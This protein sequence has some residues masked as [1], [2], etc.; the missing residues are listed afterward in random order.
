VS[1]GKTDGRADAGIDAK[2]TFE[3]LAL[4][5]AMPSGEFELA[6]IVAPAI[7]AYGAEGQTALELQ[8]ALS[9]LPREAHPTTVARHLLPDGVRLV[10]L[11]LLLGRPEL[12]GRLGRP[13]PVRI[14]VAVVPDVRADDAGP[15]GH[16]VFVPVLQHA[17]YVGRKEELARRLTDELA[18]LPSALALDIDGWRRLITYAPA[19]IEPVAV[20]LAT[21]P[22][23]EATG[24]KALAELERRR[25]AIT[26]LDGAGRRVT[27]PHP[28]PPVVGRDELLG[29]LSRVLGSAGRRSVLLV[30]DEAAGKSALVMAWVARGEQRDPRVGPA[31]PMWA[32]SAAEL[33]A[34]ASGPG[35]WQDRIAAVLTAAEAL[36]A[37]LYF[38]DFGALFADRPAE[39]GVELGAAMRRSIVDGRVRV[40]GELTAVALDRAERREVSLIGA[41]LRI[42]VP[43]TDPATTVMACHAWAA[44]WAHTAPHRPQ[45]AA[46]AV[47]TAVELAR[48]YLPYRA[49]PGKA[50][51]L[52][53]ELRV[54]HDAGRD[55]RGAGPVLGEPELYAAFSW[56]TGIPE[57]LLADDRS[58]AMAEVIAALRRRMV[59]Q[60]AA[61]R[62]VAE[63]ICVAK[64]RLAPADKPLASLLFVGPS[65]VGK[66]ELA[67]AVAAYLFGAPDRMVRLDMSEY[68][69]PWAAERL[70]GGDG[71]G[72]GRLTA[73]VRS[74]PFGVVLLDEIEKAHPAVFDLL[75]QVLGE[76]RLTDG[77]G[78]TTYFHNAIIVLTSNLGTRGARG[79]LGLVTA[80]A[81]PD[82][83]ARDERRYRDAVL[84]A[85]RP[86]LINRLDQIVVFHP[87][88]P[89]EIAR[90][91]EIAVGRLA[92][93]RGLTQSGVSLDI[94]P[95]A[96]E[97]LAD[98]GFSAELGARALRR[99]LEDALMKPA[100][101][102]L[103]RAGAEARGGTLTVRATHALPGSPPDPEVPRPS[104]ARLGEVTGEIT[105]T[106]WR[107]AQATG[108]RMVR[109]ALALATL[110]RDAD[111]EL[112]LPEAIAVRDRIAELE[113]TLATAAGHRRA[114]QNPALPGHEIA[115]LAT[116]HARLRDRWAAC[117]AGQAELHAA[118]ELG[119]EALAR[120][121][122]AIDLIDAAVAQRQKFRRDLFWLV[123]AQKPVRPGATLLVHSPDARAA[124]VAWTRL[125][126][127]AA[128]HRQWR[129]SVHL[130]GEQA[131]GWHHPWGP[132]HDLAWARSSFAARAHPAALVRIAGPGADV[133]FGLEA[134]LHR[135][136]GLAGEPCHVWVDALEPR[137]EF[138]EAEWAALPG[139]PVPR[140]PRGAPMRDAVVDG[141]RTLVAG[142]DL[143][144]PWAE[145]PGRL[146]EAALVRVLAPRAKDD[147]ELWVWDRPLAA[148]APTGSPGAAP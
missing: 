144:L 92:E 74:Q 24:R 135:L 141:D 21:T 34:G 32:T 115:R 78:R 47:P 87:L 17:C 41:M 116:E 112:A 128:A 64:A 97:R 81:E 147:G 140:T 8:L 2:L 26:T 101:R 29:E 65:G 11:E 68:T 106:L 19:A 5:R 72:D 126:L 6:P 105:I 85:F 38:D 82:R 93:R 69:D 91:A 15:A 96:L 45:I 88:R 53:E 103:A 51:R 73:A 1:D 57:A 109:S 132:P 71:T 66:T 114:S 124:V 67:R 42:A 48:R 142:D 18:A 84:A 63:A 79:Q 33:V 111:R 50:V 118:E 129:G 130:W 80:D 54:A 108:R 70:F 110:R 107:R 44:H 37:I 104:G 131:P 58:L 9:E 23:A 40:I 83:L 27:V 22:L 146:E 62:R 20:E 95:G 122:D 89:A 35:E 136:H 61:V 133:L 143:E 60:D 52:L 36:D 30:G 139:P 10:E 13:F 121:V 117:A 99:H 102:L 59:G 56:S 28:A 14:T 46:A 100:A 125:V 145:L 120:D 86:E 90:V 119:L 7:A 75:L 134:G 4:R 39:G 127:E 43:P 137:T 148:L 3:T 94:S 31:R 138:S 25:L 12:P 77:R 76:A 113:A 98:R 49:F 55:A 123:T 16:W